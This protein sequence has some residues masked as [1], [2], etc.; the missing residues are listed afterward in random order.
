MAFSREFLTIGKFRKPANPALETLA[1][2]C[3][4]LVQDFWPPLGVSCTFGVSR[5]PAR[6]VVSE[7]ISLL[8]LFGA[9]LRK[10]RGEG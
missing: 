5:K 4:V 6:V 8:G 3:A 9:I 2:T 7:E 10:E 1:N